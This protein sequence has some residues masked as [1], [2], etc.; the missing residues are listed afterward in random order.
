MPNLKHAERHQPSHGTRTVYYSY[1][2]RLIFFPVHSCKY[3]YKNSG[4]PQ[5]PLWSRQSYLVVLDAQWSSSLSR[6]RKE[7][8]VCEEI[9]SEVS[10][11]ISRPDRKSTRLN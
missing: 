5:V 3:G 8:R 6:R 10:L 7:F 9:G 1:H 11:A 2:H 4:L